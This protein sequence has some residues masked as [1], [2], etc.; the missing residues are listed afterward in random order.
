VSYLDALRAEELEETLGKRRRHR[1]MPW[2]IRARRRD[3]T[4]RRCTCAMLRDAGLVVAHSAAAA[5]AAAGAVAAAVPAGTFL[6]LLAA[7]QMAAVLG[8]AVAT[9]L[10]FPALTAI[11][12]PT[13]EPPVQPRVSMEVVGSNLW[14]DKLPLPRPAGMKDDDNYAD[15]EAGGNAVTSFGGGGGGG[16]GAGAGGSGTPGGAGSGGKQRGARGGNRTGKGMGVVD[17]D[18]EP[19]SPRERWMQKKLEATERQRANQTRER[20]FAPMAV[21]ESCFIEPS[22]VVSH[23]HHQQ[24]HLG[25]DDDAV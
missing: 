5:V 12:G 7:H 23:H 22:F 17:N 18:A 2:R 8:A 19:L 16:A 20:K 9:L 6:R 4:R 3:R 13:Y 1:L 14:K 21:M 24:Q 25:G 15:D 10:L 11:M